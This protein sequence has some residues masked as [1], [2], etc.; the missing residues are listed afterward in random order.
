MKLILCT[1]A[2]SLS[3]LASALM[4]KDLVLA[5]GKR[6]RSA[7]PKALSEPLE[8]DGRQESVVQKLDAITAQLASLN[9][10]MALLEDA[11]SHA[12]SRA[13]APDP[14]PDPLRNEIRALAS[15][16]RGIAGSLS[17]LESLPRQLSEQ[18]AYLGKSFARLEQAAA[19]TPAPAELAVS[20]DW[21]VQKIDAI[22]GY[23]TPLY[24]YLGLANDPGS[25][26]LVAAYPSIDA[27]LNALS[28]DLADVRAAVADVRRNMI[29]PVVIEPTKYQR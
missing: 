10:R 12:P 8:P 1:L 9:R 13:P 24:T 14:L 27:R 3:V 20:L 19:A 22:D 16:M 26:D 4:S 21:M 23:F 6:I 7:I 28:A 25:Q 15:G 18:T 17:Q 29:V 5:E 2:V 11:A